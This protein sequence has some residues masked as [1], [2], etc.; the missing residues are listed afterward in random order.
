MPESTAFLVRHGEVE[1]PDHVVYA[2]LPGFGLSARGV[3]QAESAAGRLSVE[4][5]RAVVSSPLR[6]A[7]ETAGIIA[8]A[9][10]ITPVGDP[11][12]TEWGL[13]DRWAGTVWERLP[14]RFPGEL[15]AYLE[16]PADL[17][18]SPESLTEVAERTTRTIERWCD[19]VSGAIVFVAHQDPIQA[20]RLALTG[21]DLASLPRDKPGHGGVIGVRAEAGAWSEVTYWEPEQGM[22]FPPAD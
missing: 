7:W 6:R 15:E 20:A 1:N 21:R 13:S 17:R 19:S 12:L 2:A 11:D 14:D 8:L 22:A 16:H 3:R 18:F 4:P 5:I 9:H 10:G